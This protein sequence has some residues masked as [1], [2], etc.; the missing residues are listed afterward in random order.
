[1]YYVSMGRGETLSP[2]SVW[3]LRDQPIVNAD[4]G[5][6]VCSQMTLPYHTLLNL[7]I[8]GRGGCDREKE[9]EREKERGK[10]YKEEE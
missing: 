3:T 8:K 2:V 6:S 5:R 10:R 4:W 1:M 7:V 9:R